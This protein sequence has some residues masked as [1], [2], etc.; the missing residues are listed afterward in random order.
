MEEKKK[1]EVR[2]IKKIIILL[3]MMMNMSVVNAEYRFV[4]ADDDTETG[5]YVDMGTVRV[6]N[7]SIRG[8]IAVVKANLNKMYV[9][10]VKINYGE[11][12]YQ[13]EK[14]E[15]L[16]YNTKRVIESNDKVRG[17]RPYSAK[18]QMSELVEYILHG[19]SE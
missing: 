6:E 15:I 3:L 19:E 10:E 11:R 5:Y 16:E 12:E 17:Y 1:N 4:D 18:S 2:K 9:Y 8:K 7:G 14:S 13:I